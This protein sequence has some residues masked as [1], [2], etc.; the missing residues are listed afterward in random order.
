[1]VHMFEPLRDSASG[2]NK[3]GKSIPLPP[4]P[5]PQHQ[6]PFV[7]PAVDHHALYFMCALDEKGFR[8][9][10]RSS[11]RFTYDF[12]CRWSPASCKPGPSFFHSKWTW[13]NVCLH[14]QDEHTHN[15]KSFLIINSETHIRS[16]NEGNTVQ[17]FFYVFLLLTGEGCVLLL[18]W[19]QD[20]SATP[21]NGKCFDSF[22]RWS[23]SLSAL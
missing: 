11:P 6:N 8:C 10:Q 13:K 21:G 16:S 20:V 7:G 14:M 5:P 23:L 3:R 9:G 17:L 22:R 19:Q 2:F 4:P 15:T 12:L 1:M 18:P